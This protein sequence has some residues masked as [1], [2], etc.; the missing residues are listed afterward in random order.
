M[1]KARL[2][3]KKQHGKLA[4][5]AKISAHTDNNSREKN[6]LKIT[7]D[8]PLSYGQPM[9]QCKHANSYHL[10]KNQK[11]KKELEPKFHDNDIK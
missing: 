3:V 1:T 2:I 7:L 6:E 4:Y 5:I 10:S 9:G 11:N 8:V